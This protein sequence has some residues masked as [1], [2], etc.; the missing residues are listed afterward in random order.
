[1]AR[2]DPNAMEAQQNALK[3]R[4]QSATAAA[5]S[6]VADMQRLVGVRP[7]TCRVTC[8]PSVHY[9]RMMTDFYEPALLRWQQ[10]QF[11][12]HWK[13]MAFIN[14]NIE[15]GEALYR[16]KHIYNASTGFPRDF[17]YYNKDALKT[18]LIYQLIG[19]HVLPEDESGYYC[20]AGFSSYL[21]GVGANT[22]SIGI[23]FMGERTQSERSYDALLQRGALPPGVAGPQRAGLDA[24][25]RGDNERGNPAAM[26]L[27]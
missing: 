25:L 7:A 6:Q 27:E 2:L 26:D 19:A 11:A 12:A 8:T 14:D 10:H 3:D 18:C 24:V 23:P 1:M 17:V 20:S 9:L 15:E 16:I 22:K 21:L 5:I 13:T 4:I